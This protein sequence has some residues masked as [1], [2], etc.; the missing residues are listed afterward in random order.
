MK[1]RLANELQQDSIVDGEGIRM[2]L[3]TQGC[4]HNCP[5]CHNQETH[6]FEGGFLKDID[7]LKQ[8][9]L[10]VKD[11]DGITLSGG[12]PFFQVE[13]CLEIA[14]FCQDNHLNVWCYTGFTF[15]QLRSKNNPK[16]EEF[17]KHIDVLVDGLFVLEQKSL[18][19]K[20]RGSKNQR[21]INVRESLKKN[22]PVII[23]KY[24]TKG[25]NDKKKQHLF[26]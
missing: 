3:W 8:E 10:K 20:F 1:I 18:S 9:I 4:A 23:R 11:H 26:I 16:I 22:K 2:V 5:G 7:E 21:I 19:L 13:P 12:D 14:K 25:N 6:S 17:L 24:N 15:E